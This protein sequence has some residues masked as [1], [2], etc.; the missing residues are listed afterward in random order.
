M[1]APSSS[2]RMLRIR[3]GLLKKNCPGKSRH[4]L[5]S[6]LQKPA[7]WKGV[8]GRPVKGSSSWAPCRLGWGGRVRRV[9]R[10]PCHLSAFVCGV[11]SVK[12]TASHR[13]CLRSGS[14]KK[15]RINFH[16][17]PEAFLERSCLFS[18]TFAGQKP[19]PYY[20]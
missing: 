16:L 3:R 9:G 1:T 14:K 13:S 4:G 12:T 8:L 6:G 2:K 7:S 18:Q 15:I 10:G 5:E 17:L 11:P 20:M 19:T